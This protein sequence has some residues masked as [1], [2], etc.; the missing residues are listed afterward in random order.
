MG[1]GESN[2]YQVKKDRQENKPKM[3]KQAQAVR[4]MKENSENVNNSEMEVSEK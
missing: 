3:R 1:V 4:K 2:L